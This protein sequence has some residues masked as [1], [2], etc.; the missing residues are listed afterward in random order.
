MLS[1]ERKRGR[2]GKRKEGRGKEKQRKGEK[3][4]NVTPLGYVQG[5]TLCPERLWRVG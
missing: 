3:G 5:S 1:K 4:R 2:E